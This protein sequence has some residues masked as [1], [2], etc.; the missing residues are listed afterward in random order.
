MLIVKIVRDSSL[1]R[2]L[3]SRWNHSSVSISPTCRLIPS[4]TQ[5]MA[6]SPRHRHNYCEDCNRQFATEGAYEQVK[7]KV[8]C[9]LQGDWLLSSQHLA[10]SPRHQDCSSEHS[11]SDTESSDDSTDEAFCDS[12]NR[13]FVD[14]S[15]LNQHLVFNTSHNWCFVCSRDF[16]SAQALDQVSFDVWWCTWD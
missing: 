2:V 6:D 15:A 8:S 13:S 3:M 12:C 9:T 5:H 7:S 16:S 11:E 14:I 10:D 1:P 4:S